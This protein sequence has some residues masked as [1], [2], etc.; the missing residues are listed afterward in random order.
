MLR[1]ESIMKQIEFYEVVLE[2]AVVLF[3]IPGWTKSG[4]IRFKSFL[5]SESNQEISSEHLYSKLD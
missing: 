4:L 5:G 3:M 1:N 2:N